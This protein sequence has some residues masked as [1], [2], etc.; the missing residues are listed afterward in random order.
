MDEI[1]K[2]LS[3]FGFPVAVATFLLVR[4][5]KRMETLEGVI[6]ELS[7]KIEVLTVVSGKRKK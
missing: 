4:I 6:R 2:I 7:E 3:Q 1:T 5:E